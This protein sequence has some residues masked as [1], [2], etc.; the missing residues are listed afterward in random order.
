MV[1]NELIN[2]FMLQNN[3]IN[4][5][6]MLISLIIT[7][8]LSLILR[9]I[10]IK[11]GTSLS[12]KKR[13]ANNFVLISVTTTLVISIIKSS[14]ALSLGLVGSL[15][16]IRFRT[17]IKDPEELSFLFF[18]IVIGLGMGANKWL[19]TI[20]SFIII[21]I[22]III[23]HLISN[24]KL[25][26]N[27]NLVISGRITKRFSVKNIN[28]I[29]EKY[30]QSIILKRFDQKDN[31]IEIVYFIDFKSFDFLER[32]KEELNNLSSSINISY[33]DIDV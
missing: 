28:R 14:L 16:I 17:A 8:I 21:T 22:I 33:F 1:S 12:N 29:L 7:T 26:N 25:N 27:F 32:A 10:Y 9:N 5:N 6:E 23:Q 13:F 31:E 20:I 30:C 11:F 18:N 15:S 4:I 24:N 2:L 3:E 19:L